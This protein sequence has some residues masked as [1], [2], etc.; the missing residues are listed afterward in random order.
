MSLPEPVGRI[1]LVLEVEP[2]DVLAR[3]DELTGGFESVRGPGGAD[4]T[5]NGLVIAKP[6]DSLG[7]LVLVEAALRF[8]SG[9]MSSADPVTSTAHTDDARALATVVHHERPATAVLGLLLGCVV[10]VH[11]SQPGSGSS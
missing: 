5:T 9:L 6:L 10:V 11:Q 3:R 7:L 2:T 1:L 8:L 4:G